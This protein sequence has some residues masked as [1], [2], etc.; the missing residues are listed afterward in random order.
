MS[1]LPKDLS[2]VSNVVG[3]LASKVQMYTNDALQFG[4]GASTTSRRNSGA[5]SNPS[6]PYMQHSSPTTRGADHAEGAQPII[7]QAF[8]FVGGQGSPASALASAAGYSKKHDDVEEFSSFANERPE[9]N[10]GPYMSA[11]ERNA[12]L[13]KL[14]N[15]LRL[16]LHRMQMDLSEQLS[17][18]DRHIVSLEARLASVPAAVSPPFQHHP[19]S[20][21]ASR[22][23]ISSDTSAASGIDPAQ[24][25]ATTERAKL[26]QEKLGRAVAHLKRLTEE[27][28]RLSTRIGELERENEGLREKTGGLASPV[29]D[30][31]DYEFVKVYAAQLEASIQEVNQQDEEL[32]AKVEDLEKK[33]AKSQK[34]AIG[35]VEKLEVTVA[36]LE[37]K[38]RD[39]QTERKRE[40]VQEG[41]DQ[42]AEVEELKKSI[43][44]RDAAIEKLTVSIIEANAEV[45]TMKADLGVLRNEGDDKS[46]Q[47]QKLQSNMTQL[48][49]EKMDAE[50]EL[51]KIR[52]ISET[53]QSEIQRMQSEESTLRR[54]LED[55]QRALDACSV[56]I[57][58]AERSKHET[59]ALYS[60]KLKDIAAAH[61]EIDRLNKT[62]L[63]REAE[64]ETLTNAILERGELER[65]KADLASGNEELARTAWQRVLASL[66]SGDLNIEELPEGNL[67]RDLV[68]QIHDRLKG[69][70]GLAA[71]VEG[72]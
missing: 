54:N 40:D 49:R 41:L 1:W 17:D 38:L 5:G 68:L 21:D 51:A 12:E 33:L 27:N 62:L 25:Q 58:A 47:I 31:S 26:L 45:A 61:D 22:L 8:R 57:E 32:K 15:N 48:E 63:E 42:T 9:S 55:M 71:S 16:E 18:R 30:R 65:E 19:L 52:D 69:S 3:G 7:L 53:Q 44:E 39:V 23:S 10:N 34:A 13:E 59:D 20:P 70:D 72:G 37:A 4:S 14:N 2:S 28:A 36:D 67:V 66:L 35:S 50:A 43:L 64:I 56:E 11:E 6:S 60:Q 24:F 46:H 29:V